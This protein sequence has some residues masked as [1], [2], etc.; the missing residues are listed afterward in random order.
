MVIRSSCPPMSITMAM[1]P[2][3]PQ[4]MHTMMTA[5]P[6]AE[7]ETVVSAQLSPVVETAL[8]VSKRR[9]SNDSPSSLT[10]NTVIAQVTRAPKTMT[11]TIASR[12][13]ASGTARLNITVSRFPRQMARSVVRNTAKVV[14]LMPPPAP[15]GAAPM[16]IITSERKRMAGWRSSTGTTVNP[17]VRGVTA[18]KKAMAGRDEGA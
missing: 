16:N 6:T 2:R 7:R 11:M 4:N 3:R 8:T 17:H 10:S 14:I 1:A 18:W 13:T 5:R 15:P 12:T 9:Y